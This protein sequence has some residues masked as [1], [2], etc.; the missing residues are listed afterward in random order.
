[1]TRDPARILC[2]A[3][4]ACV[5]AAGAVPAAGAARR[6]DVPLAAGITDDDVTRAIEK[7]REYLLSLRNADGSFVRDPAWRNCYTSLI[8]M[9]L[10]YMGEH[11]N[12]EVM[13]SGMEYLLNL[14]PER[15]FVGREGYALPIR[16]MALAYVHNKLTDERRAMARRVISADLGRIIRGQSGVGGWRYRYNRGD[17]DF[18]ATQWDILAFYEAGRL[19]I[20]FPKEPLLAARNFYFRGQKADGGWSYQ[21]GNRPY[22]SMTAAGL[23]SLQI[24]ADL[25]EPASGCPC[26]DGRSQP[27]GSETERRIDAALMWLAANFSATTNPGWPHAL[28]FDEVY[29]WLY[30]MERVGIAAGYKH[31]GGHNWYKEGAAF[32]LSRQLPDGSWQQID[33]AIRTPVEHWG[34]GRVPDTCFAILFLYKGR[35]PV[36]F[37]KLR[38]AGTWNPHR[39]DVAN[40]TRYVEW[41]KEQ[42]FHWQIVDLAAP[43]DELHDAPILYISAESAPQWTDAEKKKLRAFT[44]TG[45]TVLFEASCGNPA[46]RDWFKGFA[47]EVW[48][49]WP[50]VPLGPDHPVFTDPYRLD[51]RPELMGIGDGLRTILYYAMDDVSCPWHTRAFASREYLFRWGINLYSCA[52]DRAPLRAKLAGARPKP[53]ER[54]TATTRAGPRKTLHLARLKTDGNWHAGA[55]YGCF[56][57]LAD[58]LKDTLGLALSVAESD[59]P[60]VTAGGVAATA[61]KDFDAAYLTGTG[62]FALAAA[63]RDALRTWLAG[64]GFLWAEAAGGSQE[65]DKAFRELAGAAGWRLEPLPKDH[66][67]L[68]GRLGAAAGYDLASGVEFRRAL[69]IPRAKKDYAELWGVWAGEKMVGVYSP[70]DLV[71][72]L[73]PY[74]AHNLG[75]YKAEDAAAAVTNIVLYLTARGAPA[76]AEPTPDA[77]AQAD[78]PSPA[79]QPGI[80]IPRKSEGGAAVPW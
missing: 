33:P 57:H 59:T 4:A 37:N 21:F 14:D 56:R 79:R 69:R 77:P 75:G 22:G 65:F 23:A 39:R 16:I 51:K 63:D 34:G 62:P 12:R 49:E 8:L 60:P 78:E 5:A 19:G 41:A 9:T 74:E 27:S 48:P 26:K 11:P 7:G 70:L 66:P 47:A 36:L 32:L 72:S 43:L 10:A 50:L 38:F 58:H 2:L 80:G 55:N 24:I 45:G 46:V 31:F 18:S 68:T 54:Y 17:Y 13:R 6:S 25:V 67:L 3:L 53:S 42:Q 35:A 40:L 15:D 73:S 1:M 71:F 61:L 76:G 64:D 52:T 30:C 44:D 20:E 29:Y 28:N